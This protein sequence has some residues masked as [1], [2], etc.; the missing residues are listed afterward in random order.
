MIAVL[1]FGKSIHTDHS[2]TLAN[3]LLEW[4]ILAQLYE[5]WGVLHLISRCTVF[6]Q[7]PLAHVV[8]GICHNQH[9]QPAATFPHLVWNRSSS[10]HRKTFENRR[11]P[12]GVSPLVFAKATSLHVH[13][14]LR[15]RGERR[16]R[17]MCVHWQPVAAAIR[18][19]S[20]GLDLC[21]RCALCRPGAWIL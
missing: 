1:A 14:Q 5:T 18:D 3:A 15:N 12:F 13:L 21:L 10:Q 16:A 20:T 17:R 7:H 4:Q 2:L 19:Q 6:L 9:N 11:K 8:T